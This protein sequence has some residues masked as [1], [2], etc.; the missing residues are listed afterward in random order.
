MKKRL[1]YI[2][3]LILTGIASSAFVYGQN[4]VLERL[5]GKTWRWAGNDHKFTCCEKIVMF[6]YRDSESYSFY[7]SDTPTHTQFDDSK[8]GNVPNGRYM[9]RPG[10]ANDPE[11]PVFVNEIVALN[12]AELKLRLRNGV[13]A[14]FRSLEAHTMQYVVRNAP[15]SQSPFSGLRG[16]GS[17]DHPNVNMPLNT[18]VPDR[19]YRNVQLT[20]FTNIANQKR[21]RILGKFAVTN[22]NHIVVVTF[23][24]LHNNRTDVLCLVNSSGTILRTIEGMVIVDG[25]LMKDYRLVSG[26]VEIRQVVPSSS[27]ASLSFDN[28]TSFTGNVVTTVYSIASSSFDIIQGRTTTSGVKTFTRALLTNPDRTTVAEY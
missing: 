24:D 11:N 27:L 18:A 25:M 14:T 1:L 5:Q 20:Q 13:V 28:V 15:T 21:G 17:Q 23:G 10:F 12:D 2:V 3:A 7:L 9:I 19:L 6:D 4:T 16:V 26:Q 22:N 8:V